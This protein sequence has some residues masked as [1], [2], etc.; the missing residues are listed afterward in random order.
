VN[1]QFYLTVFETGP[2]I[3][4]PGATK[5]FTFE[6][7]VRTETKGFRNLKNQ[8]QSS[9]PHPRNPQINVYNV[10]ISKPEP[11]VMKPANHK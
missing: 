1:E 9:N 11:N 4:E 8:V 7:C 6:K 3:F 5:V 2:L 10:E